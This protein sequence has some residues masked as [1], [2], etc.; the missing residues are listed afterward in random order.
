LSFS[1]K[2]LT[3]GLK[4]SQ[5]NWV[6][7]LREAVGQKQKLDAHTLDQLEEALLAGD[8]GL[9]V[10]EGVVRALKDDFAQINGPDEALQHL[11]SKL[12]E[13]LSSNGCGS[14]VKPQVILLLGVNGT[15][16]TTTAGKL[17]A[18]FVGAG[19]RVLL[20]GCDTFRAAA[21]QQLQTWA[22]RSGADLVLGRPEGDPAAV[23]FDA[24]QAAVARG[25]DRLI[26]D[27][28][29]RLHTR[30]NLMAELQKMARVIGKVIPEAPH[31]VWLVLD[32]TTGQ[33]GL[34]QAQEFNRSVPLSGVI[35]TKMDGTARGGIIFAIHES[36]GVPVKYVGLG[37]ATEDL[38]T[39]DPGDFVEALFTEPAGTKT[40]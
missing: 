20:A 40:S 1:L 13:R 3:Q 38:D 12:T 18:R 25:V 36:L 35:L 30:D 9:D 23:A 15:G 39:F 24:T 32:S 19:E 10:S 2:R 11:K 14:T 22:D 26:I 8:V 34:R 16:K 37:E 5:T 29:G 17:A 27:T 4:K 21:S 6:A 31:E 28:A 33:N 7:R